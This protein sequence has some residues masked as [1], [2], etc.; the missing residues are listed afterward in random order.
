MKSDWREAWA[1]SAACDSTAVDSSTPLLASAGRPSVPVSS[2]ISLWRVGS[3]RSPHRTIAG[4]I[5]TLNK[6]P[7][8]GTGAWPAVRRRIP[9]PKIVAA[10][11]AAGGIACRRGHLSESSGPSVG[12]VSPYANRLYLIVKKDHLNPR[13]FI[14]GQAANCDVARKIQNTFAVCAPGVATQQLLC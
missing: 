10:N 7:A 2:V 9:Y 3:T 1:Q 12:K 5:G 4:R 11:A 13:G 6:R 8:S 14:V